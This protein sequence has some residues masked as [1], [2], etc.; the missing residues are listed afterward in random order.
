MSIQLSDITPGK[1]VVLNR[2]K[3]AIQ[4]TVLRVER[5]FVTLREAN[6]NYAPQ[7]VDYTLIYK[8]VT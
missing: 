1:T 5:H 2:A 4:Y 7:T 3:D 8:C 6:T